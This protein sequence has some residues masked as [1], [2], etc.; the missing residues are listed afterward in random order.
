MTKAED[1]P[2]SAVRRT[3]R[4]SR[5]RIAIEGWFASHGYKPFPF[6]RRVW[7]AYAAG[8][9]GLLH[10]S[11]GSGKT[12][13]V[14]LGP[15]AEW[16]DDWSGEVE[17][18][19][20]KSEPLRVLWLTPLR[21]LALDT[22]QA[23]RRPIDELG[24]PWT[25]EPRTGDTSSSVR[26]RQKERLPTAL[27]TTPES[28]SL[29]LSRP[30]AREKFATL[31]AVVVDEWHELLA[32]KRGVQ[33]ELCLAR[34]KR[35]RPELKIWGL[36]ATLG[37]LREAARIVLGPD[38]IVRDEDASEA[39]EPMGQDPAT[40]GSSPP[41]QAVL[42][43][44]HVKKKLVIDSIIPQTMERFPWAGHLG[45]R[46]LEEVVAALDEVNTSLVF[47]NTRS[48]TEI[49]YQQILARRPDW[50]GRL[51]L[52]HGSLDPEV[53]EWVE[54]CLRAG[55][56]KAVVCTS[57]LDLGVDF[58]PVERVLQIGSP[59][60]VARLVQRAGRSGHRPGAVSRVTCV[61]TH[62]LELI[63]TAATRKA[64]IAGHLEGREGV[65]APLDVLA[66]HLLTLA[67]GE[68]F[69]EA[70][71][72][73]EV[74]STWSYRDLTREEWDWAIQ[75]L[76]TGGSAL[77]AYPEYRK[78]VL[79]EG[80][81]VVDDP[82]VAKRHRLSIGTIVSDASLTVQ[83]VGGKRL[84]TVE[85]SF[86]ARLKPGD[87][88]TFAGRHLELAYVRD[89]KV[90]VRAAKAK[91]SF[92]PRWWGGRMPLS[93]QLSSAMRDLLELAR[94]GIY[95]EPEMK[96]VRPLLE[97]QAEWSAIPGTNQLLIEKTESREGFHLFVF[98]FAGR[99]VHEG[100]AALLAY[101]LSRIRSITFTMSANDYGME[102]LSDQDPPVEEALARD[103]FGS[104]RLDDDLRGS[105]NETEMAKR[106]FREVAR[107][108]GL[109]FQ[110]YPG[111]RMTSRQMQASTGL[112][113]DVFANYDPDNLLLR[114]SRKEVMEQQLERSRLAST[115]AA[116]RQS[117]I[118]LRTPPRFSPMS[119]PLTVDRLREKLS[120]EKLIDRV[121]RMQLALEKA[122]GPEKQPARRARPR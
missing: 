27:V 100:L 53:R 112:L 19:R 59:K 25:I 34:L 75:F 94:Q 115:L 28:L 103:W 97:L 33:A 11:T 4:R 46:L 78:L 66:Q 13:A 30:D 3:S 29:L 39:T 8:K 86:V 64:A 49:W 6:Q 90:Y 83:F 15:V 56:L 14:W 80:R 32:S 113:Y 87:R 81:Y 42:V 7:D 116:M 89:M 102:L 73:D 55:T 44:G 2:K 62:A 12:Y 9:S 117:E 10:A 84:G 82:Q 79:Q 17:G 38:A 61:P 93:S 77:T 35:W 48:Q 72:L 105:L 96:A 114:Q 91:A 50:A 57:S 120:S 65:R 122:A 119:F 23:L 106:Q 85:E 70:S 110:G 88:F 108:A 68:G 76:V 98:P 1:S 24:L 99:L 43:H 58:S 18:G 51:A 121:R 104:D 16:L 95:A 40:D 101:R 41:R 21:A 111:T 60:G 63:E 92:V 107:I 45:I 54:S 37:N 36:S 47:T 67:V 109:I 31:Q 52:H 74:R 71:A 22:L 26:N 20:E 118:L 69:E 5:G